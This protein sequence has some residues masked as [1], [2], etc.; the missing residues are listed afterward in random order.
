MKTAILAPS[1]AQSSSAPS[2]KRPASQWRLVGVIARKEITEMLRDSR[3]LWAGA[4]VVCLLGVAMLLGWQQAQRTLAERMSARNL[5]YSQWLEQGEKNPH[6][7]AHFGQYAFKTTSPL[8]FLDPG[9]DPYAGVTVWM[10]AHKQNEFKYRPARDATSL[11][12]FGALSVA[13]VLQTMAPLL[14]ILLGFA[15]FTGERERGTLRQLLSVGVRP[16]HLLLGKLVSLSAWVLVLLVPVGLGGLWLM[17]TSSNPSTPTSSSFTHSGV[18]LGLMLAGYAAYLV[19]FCALVLAVSAAL[20]SSR[21]A[22]IVLLAFWVVNSFVAPRVLTDFARHLSPN[23]TAVEFQNR[24]AS[25][26]KATFGHDEKHPAFIAFRDRILKQHNVLKVADLPADFR[27]F[28]LREDD[29]NGYRI[30]DNNYGEL[31]GTYLH[32]ERIRSA[33]GW[34][35]PL[36]A[37]QPL[38]LGLAGTDTAHHIEFARA[39]EAY[40]RQIQTMV[41]DELMTNVK[42]GDKQYVANRKLWERLPSFTETQP[43]L[44]WELAQQWPNGLF[45]LFWCGGTL[46][47]AGWMTRRLRPV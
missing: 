43:A 4:I 38:S 15:A 21:Q 27:G 12:R 34:A 26:R 7:A 16:A 9:V 14:I 5:T 10:E 45:L 6:S 22:L 11:Q 46:L 44:S 39:A 24:L 30:F 1:I 19:G 29:E 37:M 3:L 13:F 32:Q 31:W 47:F 2:A 18:Q 28:A 17:L 42:P 20:K 23:P 40:R 35:F 8:A 36:L 25:E 41:S 33:L